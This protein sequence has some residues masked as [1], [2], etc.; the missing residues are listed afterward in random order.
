VASVC[1][2]GAFYLS[3]IFEWIIQIVTMQKR[4]PIGAGRRS[5]GGFALFRAKNLTSYHLLET[6]FGQIPK[7]HVPHFE[8][9][10]VVQYS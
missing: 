10:Q 3:K 2:R 5:R 7:V 6:V 8:W 9:L 4:R 1:H